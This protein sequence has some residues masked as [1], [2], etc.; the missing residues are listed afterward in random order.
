MS[1]AVVLTPP[2]SVF[3]IVGFLA[4]VRDRQSMGGRLDIT[5]AW[6]SHDISVSHIDG[7]LTWLHVDRNDRPQ[8]E[9]ELAKPPTQSLAKKPGADEAGEGKAGAEGD[10]KGDGNAKDP[11][12]N[13][14]IWNSLFKEGRK[15]GRREMPQATSPALGNRAGHFANGYNG[16]LMLA[17]MALTAASQGDSSGGMQAPPAPGE[18]MAPG[19]EMAHAFPPPEVT[20]DNPIALGPNGSPHITNGLAAQQF[21]AEVANRGEAGVMPLWNEPIRQDVLPQFSAPNLAF[22]PTQEVPGVEPLMANPLYGQITLIAPPLQVSPETGQGASMGL[23]FDWRDM[24]AGAGQMDVRGLATLAKTLPAGS[25]M[26]YPAIDPR[27]L[28][29]GAV[30]L[31]LEP[32]LADSLIGRGYGATALVDTKRSARMASDYYGG[33]PPVRLL[34][35]TLSPLNRIGRRRPGMNPDSL[36]QGGTVRPT[37]DPGRRMRFIDFLGLPI[38]LSPQLNTS[39]DL[40]QESRARISAEFMPRA[41]LISPHSFANLRSQLL[42]GFYGVE[43]RPELGAWRRAAPDYERAGSALSGLLSNRMRMGAMGD[44]ITSAVAPIPRSATLPSIGAGGRMLGPS[45]LPKLSGAA[46]STRAPLRPSPF[47]P[48]S[49]PSPGVGSPPQGEAPSFIRHQPRAQTSP[50]GFR[51]SIPSMSQSQTAPSSQSSTAPRGIEPMTPLRVSPQVMISPEKGGAKGKTGT[52][53]TQNAKQAPA[54]RPPAVQPAPMEGAKPA[55]APMMPMTQGPKTGATPPSPKPKAAAGKPEGSA[56]AEPKTGSSLKPPQ[57]L[58]AP[59]KGVQGPKGENEPLAIQTSSSSPT[60]AAS[61]ES[62]ASRSA[63]VAEKKEGGMPGSEINLLA[64]E[65]WI[66]LKR[67]LAFEAQRM[68]R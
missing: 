18:T 46:L 2:A 67:R 51:P 42:G 47:S 64:N 54:S 48:P 56:P 25:R 31:R 58:I 8:K 68:G 1:D 52:I 33:T 60:G 9:K 10:A 55:R 14:H 63:E 23:T 40:E 30:N 45:A 17:S 12:V 37:D 4:D 28:R 43:A 6:D 21:G 22:A 20:V 57:M 27:Q 35:A 36:P 24:A 13:I 26:L 7:F 50:S 41:P 3:K 66:L 62:G 39:P 59:P 49:M 38:Y 11:D 53:P 32:R 65:V 16:N 19:P 44:G 15:R 5:E 61:N 34:P 29:G